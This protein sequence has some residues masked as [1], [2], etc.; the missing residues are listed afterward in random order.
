MQRTFRWLAATNDHPV[1]PRWT[2]AYLRHISASTVMVSSRPGPV[3]GH[4][5][6][7][8]LHRVDK[9][10][11]EEMIEFI[12]RPNGYDKEDDEGQEIVIEV[13]IIIGK[14]WK[15]NGQEE[16]AFLWSLSLTKCGVGCVIYG[17]SGIVHSC[18]INQR[19]Q[20]PWP[21]GIRSKGT[22][23]GTN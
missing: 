2:S 21:S 3:S 17:V 23:S 14:F 20:Y 15:I 9:W 7:D 5:R 8:S 1:V 12:N 13:V 11:A 10:D 18:N 4:S 16:D 19:M 6:S 22:E